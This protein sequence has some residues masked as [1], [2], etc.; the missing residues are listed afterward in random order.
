MFYNNSIVAIQSH[1]RQTKNQMQSIQSK[2][3]EL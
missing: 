1:E 2:L 3:M